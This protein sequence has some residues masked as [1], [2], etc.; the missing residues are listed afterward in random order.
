METIRACQR[1][2]GPAAEKYFKITVLV[3]CMI[4]FFPFSKI[5]RKPELRQALKGRVKVFDFILIIKIIRH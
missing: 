3:D 4:Y 2:L 5:P 1:Y